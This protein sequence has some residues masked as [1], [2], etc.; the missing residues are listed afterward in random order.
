[1]KIPAW[2][3][4]DLNKTWNMVCNKNELKTIILQIMTK[5]IE[6]SPSCKKQLMDMLV[7]SW[8][9]YKDSNY[10]RKYTFE[11][12][13]KGALYWFDIDIS[14]V[15]VCSLLNFIH[16]PNTTVLI[17]KNRIFSQQRCHKNQQQKERR[18][19]RLWEWFNAPYWNLYCIY[20]YI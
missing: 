14:Y 12:C 3:Y 4:I 11:I 5:S 16:N 7:N 1:M 8:V 19:N 20:T 18:T 13:W 9:L 2:I 17:L 15:C 6:S 10:K